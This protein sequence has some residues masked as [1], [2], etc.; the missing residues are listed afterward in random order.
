MAHSK[1]QPMQTPMCTQHGQ[2]GVALLTE[3]SFQTPN[4]Q[5][6]TLK[7]EW[8]SSEGSGVGSVKMGSSPDFQITAFD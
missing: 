8:T 5:Q 7:G 1:P 4:I 3:K 2:W 6:P